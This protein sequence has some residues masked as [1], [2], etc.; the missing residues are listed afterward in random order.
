MRLVMFG[1]GPFAAPTFRA[2]FDTPHT[3]VA[4]VTQ[5]VRIVRGKAA[6]APS[7]LRL[8]AERRGL[9]I[10]DPADVN[11]AEARAELARFAAD[12][13]VVAD[14]GQ[15][16]SPETLSLPSQ[17]SINL[18]GSLLPKYRGAAP[19]NWAVFHGEPVMGVSVI[20]VTPKVDAGAVY[21]QASIDV[22]PGET[23]LE[24]ETRLAALGAP[25]VCQVIDAIERGEATALPQDMAAAT[26]A[27]RLRKTD[28]AIDWSKNAVAIENQ[29]RA[30]QPWPGCYT[31][32]L[33]T[34][35][36][37][38]RLI[39]GRVRAIG[40]DLPPDM[41]ESAGASAAP[42]EVLPAEPGEL[43]VATGA[44]ALR[45]EQVQPA[46]RQMMA[47]ADFLRGHPIRPG[48]RLGPGED[49]A[50]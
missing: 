37:P 3:V 47:A 29:W 30:L 25:L 24:L 39:L 48:D 49:E 42:G 35:G 8:E 19:I 4:L 41:I 10:F 38:L 21:A 14:Y 43:R 27:R 22:A 33:R 6:G 2:L 46:G 13:Y 50:L 34:D 7:P 18:H 45:I 28:G 12:L 16:L 23:A 9:P 36:E 31:Y 5:P 15:I 1:A 26:R 32:W 11:S 20:G 44:G 40:R 17:G